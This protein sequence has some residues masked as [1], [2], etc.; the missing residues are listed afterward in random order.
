[1]I[2]GISL[3][4]I[5]A[6]KNIQLAGMMATDFVTRKLQI[7]MD[8][9]V[10]FIE[11]IIFVGLRQNEHLFPD[12]LPIIPPAHLRRAIGPARLLG[13][14]ALQTYGLLYAAPSPLVHAWKIGQAL[15]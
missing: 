9:L 7:C 5:L 4:E 12:I 15:I 10:R 3:S 8:D 14:R 6:E 1:M 13:Y 11:N 2:H